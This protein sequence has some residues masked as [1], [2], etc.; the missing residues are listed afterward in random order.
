MKNNILICN[1]DKIYVRIL[2]R[3]F[4]EYGI[5]SDT[6]PDNETLIIKK[7]SEKKYNAVLLSGFG[8][9][10][11]KSVLAGRIRNLFPDIV[12]A[13]LIYTSLYEDCRKFIS[14]GAERCII[15]PQS[16]SCVC[17]YVMNMISDEGL[18]LQETADFMT[19]YGFPCNMNGFYYFCSATEECIANGYD[20]ISPVYRIVAERFGTTPDNVESSIRHFIKVSYNKGAVQKFSNGKD[21][22]PSNHR[23]IYSVSESMSE[24]YGIFRSGKTNRNSKTQL[25]VYSSQNMIFS[26]EIFSD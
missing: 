21:F 6:V 20:R 8:D 4:T 2:S 3:N 16:V 10:G 24:F 15:M 25:L 26:P 22:R 13:V 5:V 12:T 11:K 18:Y 23:L 14:A 19:D 9:V 1:N 7:L 17:S